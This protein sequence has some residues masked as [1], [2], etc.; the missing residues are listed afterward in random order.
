MKP[1]G[2]LTRKD[3]LSYLANG[4]SLNKDLIYFNKV[5][6]SKLTKDQL[7]GREPV[8]LDGQ[9]G[10]M[11]GDGAWVKTSALKKTQAKL[12]NK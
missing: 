8:M 11:N 12:K 3:F 5:Q 4:G 10:Y 1:T 6:R 7:M 9:E 2:I